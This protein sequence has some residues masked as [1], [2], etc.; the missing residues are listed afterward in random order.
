MSRLTDIR[1][2]L[3]K[4]LEGIDAD[5]TVS[6]AGGKLEDQ[7]ESFTIRLVVGEVTDE[8]QAALDDLLGADAGSIR[9]LLL[10][11]PTLGDTVSAQQVVSHTGWRLYPQAEGPPLLGTEL[12]VTA[13][14]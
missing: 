14:L 1:K 7:S 4:A 10:A 5:V 9:G 13:Y 11:D 12:T 3:E 6:P 8:T 2:A